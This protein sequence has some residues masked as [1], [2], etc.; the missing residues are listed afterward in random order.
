MEFKK[1]KFFFSAAQLQN[2][3]N[4]CEYCE[5]KP[6]QTECPADVSP[7]DFIRAALGG[8]ASDF[9][10][11]AALI[12]E[13]NPFGATCGFTC[14]ECFCRSGCVKL[15][16][17]LSLNIPAIQAEVINRSRELGVFPVFKKERPTREKIAIIGA[18]PAGLTAA[19][20]LAQKG[21]S[22]EI[23]EKGGKPGGACSLI[24]DF[25]L[26]RK[27]LNQDIEFILSL[28]GII[29]HY[30]KKITDC[31][32]LVTSGFSAVIAAPGL[33]Q[34]F[35]LNIKNEDLAVPGLDYL[36]APAKYKMKNERV[37]V[38]GG[39]AVALDC[40]A[41]A[42]IKG[43]GQVTMIALEKLSEM[44]LPLKER[45]E[46]FEKGIMVEGRTRLTGIIAGKNKIKGIRT[47][48]VD[49]KGDAFDL[50][51]L[52][53]IPGSANIRNDITKVIIAIGSRSDLPRQK[54]KAV[55]YSGDYENGPTSVVEAVA[56]AK[57]AAEQVQAFLGNGK[58]PAAKD[59][60]KSIAIIKGYDPIPVALGSDFFGRRIATPF[61][62]SAAPP[63]DGY[64]EMKKAYE[65]GWSGGIMKTA[66]DNI[67]IHIP[68]GYMFRFDT[69]TYANCDNVS[70]HSLDRVCGE[71][72]KLV[73]EFPDRLT[74]A[75]TGGPVTGND[76]QDKQGWQSNT[77]K[78]ENCGAMA[79]EYSLSCPQ[80]GDGTKGDIVSQDAELTA[81][82]IGWVMEA[83]NAKIPKLFKLT[84]AVTSIKPIIAAI[85]EVFNKYPGKKGGITLANTFP[86]LAFRPGQKKEWEEGIVTGMSG[87][88]V[89]P[90]SYL[91]LAN[92]APLG[93]EIS[94][95]GGPMDHKATAHFLALGV[96]TVQYCT[97][98]MKSGYNVFADLCSGVSHLMEAR[99]IR[100][101]KE[102]IGIALPHPIRGFMEL[103][104]EKKISTVDKELC[105]HCGNCGRC[106]YLAITYDKKKNPVTDASRCIGCSICVQKC[107][108][109]ALSMRERTPEEKR[110]LKED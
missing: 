75:S 61:L 52:S 53:D 71:V 98:V 94:G 109:G 21:Y 80:G 101:M 63:S 62:L 12:L 14:P 28:G 54:H 10:R 88:G 103:S 11:A 76:E 97:L 83:G 70:G 6:C 65:A 64:E 110:L 31:E 47:V 92:A 79:I 55:F 29:I 82:I 46:I 99:N 73:K 105:E 22:I 78:L 104:A 67:P 77:K 35:R 51:K 58:K 27:V 23:F 50:K 19:A 66:F 17:D 68:A 56:S 57:I 91:T 7:K 72:E 74:M 95:N 42:K 3:I 9:K 44:P 1:N 40:A 18:G 106:P 38:V 90:I 8:E 32:T 100:S 41:V 102:L 48:K 25:R 59:K 36:A 60:V 81:R 45:N 37:A 15:N 107:F 34:P 16:W 43:A 20:M 2:E 85:K 96:R 39:G 13:K 69:R 24:P 86:T 84:G 108:S 87:E 93:I 5:E 26:P 30:N 49:L 89:L 4:K 33:G